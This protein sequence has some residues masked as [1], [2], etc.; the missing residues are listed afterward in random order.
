LCY[1]IRGK[2]PKLSRLEATERAEDYYCNQ[3]HGGNATIELAFSSDDGTPDVLVKVVRDRSGG[4][5]VSSPSGYPDP[6]SFLRSLNE[7]HILLDYTAFATFMED[8]ALDRG[9]S[10][11]SLLGMAH[12]SRVRQALEQLSNRGNVAR[13]FDTHALTA[14]RDRL[15][16]EH[17]RVAKSLRADYE[18]LTGELLAEPINVAG[19]TDKA[20]SALSGIALLASVFEGHTL[21]DVS[22]EALTE[23]VREAEGSEDR[24][25]LATVTGQIAALRSLAADD[26]EVEERQSLEQLIAERDRALESTRGEVFQRLYL[27]VQ[28]VLESGRWETPERCP[29]CDSTPPRPVA[30]HIAEQL[31]SFAAAT[32]ENDK[33]AAAWVRASCAGRLRDME[34]TAPLRVP[35]E[36]R[37]HA[38][39]DAAFRQGCASK[40]HVADFTARLDSLE[41]SRQVTLHLLEGEKERIEKTLPAS[42]VALTGQLEAAKELKKHIVAYRDGVD[43][44]GQ[45]NKLKRKVRQ[46]ERW[47]AFIELAA[48]EFAGAETEFSRSQTTA[49]EE[50][51]KEMYAAIMPGDEIVPALEKPS[52][53]ERLDVRL[54]RFYG[55]ENLSARPLLSESYRNAFGISVF[56]SAALDKRS[57]PRFIVLDDITSSFD[58][59]HQWF[60]M[61]LLRTKV[62]LPENDSGLQVIILSHD[63]LLEKYFDRLSNEKGWHHCRLEGQA[64]TGV[65]LSQIQECERLRAT[66]ERLLGTGQVRQAEPLI[67]QYLEFRLVQVITRVRIPVPV[68]FAI[69]DDRR[70]VQNCLDC[71]TSAVDLHQKAGDLVLDGGQVSALLG[72]YLP[73]IAANWVS[74]YE[75]KATA[76]LAPPVL[77]G[78]LKAI[79]DLA[80]C[81]RYDDSK[82][83]TRQYYRSLS[84]R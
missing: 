59:G 8:S 73:A 18:T 11:S 35:E 36:E 37:R 39:W 2:V 38:T 61:E 82:N 48:V 72:R 45:R 24:E 75:T 13:D 27:A 32:R 16:A 4:R 15:D 70:M 83:G 58:A 78:V 81:F 44:H 14:E 28:A 65:V 66:A 64:P 67:R 5:S 6:E 3:F 47:A 50:R 34:A 76:S 68:D 77:R 53:T 30:A 55:R 21:M 26:S 7:D 23:K 84:Q 42:L 12:L 19:V 10:L 60:L 79:D 51:Y 41:A 9:R 80:D 54:A 46:R 31:A 63:G 57:A 20:T 33:V 69:R 40:D 29:A 17:Q 62:G 25:R 74:H 49:L 43:P 1:A 52:G 71:I 22:F 56:L